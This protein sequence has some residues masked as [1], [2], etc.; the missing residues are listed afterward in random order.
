MSHKDPVVLHSLKP[1][2]THRKL[3]EANPAAEIEL[4]ERIQEY[5][6]HHSPG[7]LRTGKMIHIGGI[8]ELKE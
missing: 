3:L 8:S 4:D 2:Q 6:V 1:S 7:L 5:I